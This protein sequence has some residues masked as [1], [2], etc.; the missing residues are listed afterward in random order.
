MIKSGDAL[1]IAYAIQFCHGWACHQVNS[2]ELTFRQ[3]IMYQYVPQM[4]TKAMALLFQR[5]YVVNMFSYSHNEELRM[6]DF[7][8]ILHLKRNNVLEAIK[9]STF[10][11]NGRFPDSVIGVFTNPLEKI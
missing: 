5:V 3:T 1:K 6:T 7:G 10:G 8:N 9:R 11:V 2:G 4:S